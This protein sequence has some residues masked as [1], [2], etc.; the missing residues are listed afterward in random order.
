MV[1]K[2]KKLSP[3]SMKPEIFLIITTWAFS[4]LLQ[5]FGNAL[6]SNFRRKFHWTF[7]TKSCVFL[8]AKVFLKF[9]RATFGDFE[10][11]YYQWKGFLSSER[12]MEASELC[13]NLF[14]L[15]G[16]NYTVIER[17]DSYGMNYS[18]GLVVR[19]DNFFWWYFTIYYTWM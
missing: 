5:N 1:T 19:F 18:S 10:I 14:R 11:V 15:Y 7:A 13:L 6:H 3:T 8:L 4:G 12:L 9:Q 16:I 17:Y 2:T